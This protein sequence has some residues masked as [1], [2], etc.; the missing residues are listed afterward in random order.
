MRILWAPWRIQ[1]IR[2]IGTKKSQCFIC[3]YVR[4]PE[5]DERNLVLYRSKHSI[6]LMN[7]FPYINGH[8]MVAPLRHVANLEDLTLEEGADLF[9]TLQLV[10]RALKLAFKPD[11]LN[12]GVNLGR[13][14][15]AGL[16]KHLHVHVIPRWIG[17]HNFISTLADTRVIGQSL[18]EAYEEI[19]KAM[20]T[21]LRE[22][23]EGE[24]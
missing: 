24:N 18:R 13:A 9:Q 15:G 5:D 20:R 19:R 6:V 10:V 16:E 4:A 7:A 11:G 1:Y 22:E 12:V 8:V 17:D 3:D 2:S 14:A 21:I 23:T